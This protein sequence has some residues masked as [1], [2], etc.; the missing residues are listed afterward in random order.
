M[1]KNK[2]FFPQNMYINI[3]G[4]VV[5][6][7]L[8]NHIYNQ[9]KG[10]E[11]NT[12]IKSLKKNIKSKWNKLLSD[13]NY[14]KKI[15]WNFSDKDFYKKTLDFFEVPLPKPLNICAC[16]TPENVI[17]APYINNIVIPLREDGIQAR[18]MIK[19]KIYPINFE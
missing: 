2:L 6:S 19:G 5:L 13:E 16:I 15:T 14:R 18:S 9:A 11:I 3:Y 4:S 12:D 1:K 8:I 17:F 10:E 7:A